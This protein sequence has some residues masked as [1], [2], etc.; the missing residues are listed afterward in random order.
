MMLRQSF[1]MEEDAV[2]VE[3]AVR[4]VLAAGIATPDLALPGARVVGTQAMGD[5]I[6]AA[7]A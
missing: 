1:G 4:A 2:R 6:A 3:N 7:L 5:A